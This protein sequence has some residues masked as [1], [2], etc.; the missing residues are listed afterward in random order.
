[1][2]RAYTSARVGLAEPELLGRRVS[3]RAEVGGVCLRAL[4]VLA[5]YAQVDD[6]D[7]SAPGVHDDVGR[8]EIAVHERAGKPLVQLDDGV[9]QG[10]EHPGGELER[11]RTL[12]HVVGQ[13]LAIDV[14]EQHAL[15]AIRPAPAAEHPGEMPQV[16]PGL[17]GLLE[18]GVRAAQPGAAADSLE[19]APLPG[20]AGAVGAARLVCAGANLRCNARDVND[21]DELGDLV[22]GRFERADELEGGPVL[23]PV[24]KLVGEQG[25]KLLALAVCE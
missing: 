20:R 16:T 21:A 18:C 9:A 6:D 4:V 10:G 1:M 5:R 24:P 19:D 2:P 13:G 22:R 25:G 14:L 12:A 15:P 3:P 11:G 17:L 8:L 23:R 7:T